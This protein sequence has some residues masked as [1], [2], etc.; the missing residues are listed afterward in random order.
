MFIK[1]EPIRWEDIN[2]SEIPNFRRILFFNN[3]E[4][5][6][7]YVDHDCS[8]RSYVKTRYILEFY[9]NFTEGDFNLFMIKCLEVYEFLK[10]QKTVSGEIELNFN[11]YSG[12]GISTS[13]INRHNVKLEFEII[14]Y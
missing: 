6:L 13:R 9:Y 4:A 3:I 12:A 14:A 2:W 11:L 5:N 10:T 8:H 1:K 7:I